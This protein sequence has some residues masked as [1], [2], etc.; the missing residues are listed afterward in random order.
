VRGCIAL[1]VAF[2]SNSR[3][4]SGTTSNT[5]LMSVL[6]AMMSQTRTVL[7]ENHYS[8]NNLEQMFVNYR[9]HER[10]L[11]REEFCYFNQVGLESLMK[12][13]HSIQTY[14]NMIGDISMKFL[15]DKI[16]YLPKN[17]ELNQEFFDYELNQVISP[18][19][20]LLNHIGDL[21]FIDTSNE[22]NLSTKVILNEADLVVVNLCQSKVIIEQ[23]FQDFASIVSKSVFLLG[24]Y[25]SQSIF[26]LSNIRRKF[27]IPQESIAVIP[28]NME[29]HDA[30][31][32]GNVIEFVTRNFT[33]GT[34][35]ENYEFMEEA[36]QAASMILGCY[37]KRRE[38]PGIVI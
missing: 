11:L 35:D 13:V 2:W 27:H 10:N 7:F 33:C 32:S 25:Q 17:M 22:D 24:N 29:F 15:G 38:E 26:N 4:R 28:N 23:F 8:L 12:R 20:H 37:N 16:Y 9:H 34:K 31:L 19:L 5:A 21:V 30:L 6:C 1:K 36:K 14:E 3:G 18:L